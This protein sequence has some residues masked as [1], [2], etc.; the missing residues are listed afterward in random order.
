MT[1]MKY[2]R[3]EK[4]GAVEVPVLPPGDPETYPMGGVSLSH[5]FP[6]LY[7]MEGWLVR[8]IEVG[9]PV[10]MLRHVRNGVTAHG[11]FVSSLVTAIRSNHEFTTLNSVY[12]WKEIPLRTTEFWAN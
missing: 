2:I 1:Y 4:T 9:K 11:R 10:F 7:W 12:N 8:P 6:V 3:L 5:S